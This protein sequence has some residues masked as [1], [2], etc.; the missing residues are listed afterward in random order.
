MASATAHTPTYVDL[1]ALC[2]AL[3]LPRVIEERMLLLLRQG[4]L[5]KW[6][7]GW[8]QE[9]I[10]VGSVWGLRDR[11]YILPMHRNLG[12]WTA[13]GLPLE[14][15][16]CQLMGREGGYTKGR[17]RSYHFGVPEERIVGMISH[18]AAMLPVAC[19]LGQAAQLR[20]EDFVALAFVGEGAT[21]EGDFHEACNLAAVWKLPVIFL[22]ESN[23]YG[24][25]TP[26]R[27]AMAVDDIAT[28]AAGYGMAGEIADG[29]DVL[30]MIDAVRRSA[31]RARAGDGP[32]LLEAKTFRMRGHEEASGTK[33]VPDELFELWA[34]RDPVD[35]YTRRL[36]E[37][38][39]M[40]EAEIE[41]LKQELAARVVEVTEHALAQPFVQST[42]EKETADLF[43]IP[44]TDATPP[45]GPESERRFV[46]AVS[47][48]LRQ[49]MERDERVIVLGQDIAEYGGVFKVTQG[50]QTQFGAGRVRNTPIIE[51]GAIG[52]ALGLAIEGF[53]PVVEMQYA[54]FIACGFNQ[55][56]NNL[57]TSHYR[58]GAEVNVTI[59]AP[60]GGSIG[61]GP[62]HSQSVEAWFC[63]VPGLK[64]VAP[65]T[66]F[67]A[68]GLLMAAIRD[69]NPVLVFEH[70]FL[71]RGL[72]GMVPD[73]PYEVDLGKA[74]VA[75]EGTDLTLVTW[76][77]GVLWAEEE[78]TY[79]QEKGVS[80]EVIDLRSLIPWD[81]ETVL[82]SLGKTNRLLVLHEAAMTAGFG[83]E[84]AARIAEQ[85]FEL[86]DA[87]PARVAGANLPIPFSKKLED[88]IYSARSRLREAIERL[89]GY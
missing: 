66:P 65:A 45:A 59:R 20:S 61:A 31:A 39:V 74:R 79:Q 35:R 77:I 63:H 26:T 68:K 4:R 14:K 6:F 19:G 83:A 37:T 12:V 60:F 38:G 43:A 75:R 82:A 15:L 73:A 16:F 54:D 57:A 1:R 89:A 27:E 85:G 88:D 36:V 80:I 30:A 29:N 3:L 44:S 2:R 33:Y 69:P 41:Q 24:L 49:A 78:A 48:G 51:S 32:T 50:F 40:A 7:S 34:K 76:G 10:A 46:D 53:H 42:A 47:D 52:A 18:M 86:L 9:A 81:T 84:V 5:K 23:G 17:D 71:Y 64:V 11:D 87:P 72:K 8:G 58:W 28:A 25:S 13:R 22:V 56:V 62:F 70:K 21:R 67:D 55:V